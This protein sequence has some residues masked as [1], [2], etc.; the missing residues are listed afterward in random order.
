[1]R[2]AESDGNEGGSHEEGGMT[3]KRVAIPEVGGAPTAV[4]MCTHAQ[5]AYELAIGRSGRGQ[6]Y[7]APAAVGNADVDT[8]AG[9]SD[10]GGIA[11]GGRDGGGVDAHA[12]PGASVGRHAVR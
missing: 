4:V 2:I 9:S 1:V 10:A 8:A 6:G 11:V 12:P 7:C 5:G 3:H